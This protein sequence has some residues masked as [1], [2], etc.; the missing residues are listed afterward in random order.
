MKNRKL[1][2][3]RTGFA[4]G[5]VVMA[6]AI[7]AGVVSSQT[8]AQP[9]L[10]ADGERCAALAGTSVETGV[11][12]AA[13]RFAAGA[14]IVGGKTAGG[15]ASTDT[16]RVR[17]RLHPVPGSDIHVEVWLPQAWNRKLF[18][19]GGAGF[20][21]ALNPGTAALLAKATH[22]GY[23]TV[24]T[25]VGHDAGA[26]LESW[27][28]KQ[29][30]KVVDFG[31]RG[32]H[33]AAI[34]AKQVI[35]AYYDAKPQHAYFFG[36]SNG[37]RDGLMEASRYPEDYDG[38]IA[39][40]PAQRYIE[41]LTEMIWNYRAV[42]GPGGAP[43]LGSKLD[44]IHAA[45]M[46]NCDALD[47]VK[48]GILENPR[49]CHFDPAA[50]QCKGGDKPTCLTRAE[51][52]AT[53]KIYAGP[54]LGNGEQIVKGPELGGELT[55]D[56]WPGW[57]IPPQ[58]A[59]YGQEF[60]RWF[61][62]DDPSWEVEN[63]DFDRDYPAARARI[64]GIVDADGA[65]LRAFARR[66]GKLIIYEGWADPGITP[67]ATIKYYDD[68]RHRLGSTTA[69][70]V[71]LFMV[72]SMFHCAGGAGATTFD[73]QPALEAW[74]EK[75]V[76]PERVIATKADSGEPPMSHPL[77]A[78]PKIAHYDGSGST[79]DAANFSCKAPHSE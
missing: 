37:G 70:H 76:A 21:G 55:K 75:G 71:R 50:L 79:R 31:H 16:C 3:L 53:R 45:I 30:E 43:N 34:V 63:F 2:W 56:G 13:E 77:C 26:S 78:W 33:L 47:G 25:D 61:V 72:P 9:Q 10:A 59:M 65:D 68:A 67:G 23:A 1:L 52:A 19:I 7:A 27:V 15:T 60:Y 74:V 22:E 44:L 62:Y 58:T 5:G 12:E 41:V 11:V 14:K 46:K 17:L 51:V 35:S 4:L 57:I 39:G 24:A 32:N 49:L 42:H 28:H 48:D 64:G 73:M 66:G 36:C 40:D 54:R 18:A 38:V 8:S 6:G 29:P 20:D 69:D